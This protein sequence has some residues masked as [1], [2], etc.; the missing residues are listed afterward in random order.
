MHYTVKQIAITGKVK[1][2][3]RNGF[4]LFR[5]SPCLMQEGVVR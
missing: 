2:K 5:F 1:N 3:E 4:I